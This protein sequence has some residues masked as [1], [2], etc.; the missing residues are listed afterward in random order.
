[1]ISEERSSSDE[2]DDVDDAST[3]A[4]VH[5]GTS[6]RDTR[7]RRPAAGADNVLR[8]PSLVARPANLR[9]FVIAPNGHARVVVRCTQQPRQ[10]LSFRVCPQVMQRD[11]PRWNLFMN[12][13]FSI[14]IDASLP[15]ATTSMRYIL[16]LLNSPELRTTTEAS[17]SG[18]EHI[19]EKLPL[20]TL[21][22]VATFS[23]LLGCRSVMQTWID[24]WMRDVDA[25]V[26]SKDAPWLLYLAKEFGDD[27]LFEQTAR[28]IQFRS[29]VD[30]DG[31]FI[32]DD[33]RKLTGLP[34]EDMEDIIKPT[35]GRSTICFHVPWN[36]C[37][38]Y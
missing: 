37:A 32:D 10:G 38:N 19:P 21:G 2:D 1:M 5:V 6:V 12:H 25:G 26:A 30:E 36:H 34:E 27:D 16:R 23:K 13:N 7:G 17:G 15:V 28:R 24:R 20:V 29:F 11:A 8:H 3:R 18:A 33:G 31:D 14:T 9:T 4:T 35:M 22:Y